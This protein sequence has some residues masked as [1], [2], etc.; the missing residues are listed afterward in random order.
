MRFIIILFIIKIRFIYSHWTN[1][2]SYSNN[3]Q[4]GLT[5]KFSAKEMA[6]SAASKQ[7]RL[8]TTLGRLNA[9]GL[10]YSGVP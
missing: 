8:S 2:E 10:H 3:R 1:K 7:H 5:L 6:L 4:T 9:V